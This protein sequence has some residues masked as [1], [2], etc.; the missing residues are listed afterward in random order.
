MEGSPE[1]GAPQ[2]INPEASLSSLTL[3]RKDLL[4]Q[5]NLAPVAIEGKVSQLNRL[6]D[7]EKDTREARSRGFY[8]NFATGLAVLSRAEYH[9]EEGRAAFGGLAAG[10]DLFERELVATVDGT[11]DEA[12][13]EELGKMREEFTG[14]ELTP[15]KVL[16][17]VLELNTQAAYS[18][19]GGSELAKALQENYQ[20]GNQRVSMVPGDGYEEA[21]KRFMSGGIASVSKYSGIPPENQ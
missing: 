16:E 3:G 9:T 20:L 10:F 7:F 8:G 4:S 19:G 6:V 12:K 21:V 1:G 11:K 5:K 2:P 13:I 17:K 14:A 15:S 18:Y